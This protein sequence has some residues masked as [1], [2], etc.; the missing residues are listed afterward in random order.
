MRFKQERAQE[1]NMGGD[2]SLCRPWGRGGSI[3][4]KMQPQ[5]YL[6]FAGAVAQSRLSYGTGE[7]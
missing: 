5:T 1:H 7:R 3:T 2:E 4:E 6:T